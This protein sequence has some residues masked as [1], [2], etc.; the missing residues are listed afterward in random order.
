MRKSNEL[1]L[2]K[3]FYSFHKFNYFFSTHCIK[4]Q[5]GQIWLLI[6]LRYVNLTKFYT[7]FLVLKPDFFMGYFD[8]LGCL[9]LVKTS[10]I[11]GLTVHHCLQ[12]K[13]PSN[14]KLLFTPFR[15]HDCFKT[16]ISLTAF[17]FLAMNIVR[18][19]IL[20]ENF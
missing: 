13:L 14:S 8:M 10:I 7:A 3:K 12:W 20:R 9:I 4:T 2:W 18:Q 17:F 6:I 1:S 15:C 16:I 5:F 19:I 11:C